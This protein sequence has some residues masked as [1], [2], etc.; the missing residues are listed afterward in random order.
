MFNQ[1]VL[2]AAGVVDVAAR[3]LRDLVAFAQR[4]EADAARRVLATQFVGARR[5]DGEVRER[6]RRFDILSALPSSKDASSVGSSY[7]Q[8]GQVQCLISQSFTQPGW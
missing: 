7:L 8:F 3:Q 2:D 1:P 6:G 4:L 5:L